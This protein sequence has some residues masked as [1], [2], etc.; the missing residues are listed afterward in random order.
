VSSLLRLT[1]PFSLSDELHLS[2]IAFDD[3]VRTLNLSSSDSVALVEIVTSLLRLLLRD[4][5]LAVQIS[6]QVPSHLNFAS[7]DD[8]QAALDSMK[9]SACVER[10]RDWSYN[11]L[12]I[13]PRKIRLEAVDGLKWQSVLRCV[14]PRLPLFKDLLR[15][16]DPSFDML[17]ALELREGLEGDGYKG[18]N[19]DWTHSALANLIEELQLLTDA[20]HQIESHEFYSLSPLQKLSIL[21]HL[22]LACY[23]CTPVRQLLE[24]HHDERAQ[25]V[26]HLNAVR[27]SQK[28]ALRQVSVAMKT[29]A[30]EE[31]RKINAANQ[32]KGK[33]SNKKNPLDPSPAQLNAMLDDLLLMD[34]VKVH[35]VME[36]P[37]Q[38]SRADSASTPKGSRAYAAEEEKKKKDREQTNAMRTDAL[39]YLE[40]ALESGRERDI[41]E[42]IRYAK[43]AGLEGKLPDGKVYCHPTLFKV[44]IPPPPRSSSLCRSTATERIWSKPRRSRG[45]RRTTRRIW[46]SSFFGQSPSV[47]I[48][49]I[50]PTTLSRET[51][52]SG[53]R[54]SSPAPR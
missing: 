50:A 12:K 38:D 22:C 10:H 45:S 5:S 36:P 44:P 6:A 17:V 16:S 1:S 21:R 40:N 3:L 41:R 27:N 32:S 14:L 24:S 30:T 11:G 52:G 51:T 26:A 13:L 53:S 7:R 25:S 19:K 18:S 15:A 35:V 39:Y 29:R 33:K 49:T 54:L 2:P 46:R 42:S 8:E 43:Q 31:C 34:S 4:H 47:T 48:A 9:E 20:F 23:D 37:D 28:R